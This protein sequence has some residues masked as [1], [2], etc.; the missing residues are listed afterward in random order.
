[1]TTRIFEA[2]D[3]ISTTIKLPFQVRPI[4]E[5]RLKIP[6]TIQE[7]AGLKLK[8]F[9]KLTAIESGIISAFR[10]KLVQ[11]VAEQKRLMG[12][13]FT[14]MSVALQLDELDKLQDLLTDAD[15]LLLLAEKTGVDAEKVSDWVERLIDVTQSFNTDA[16][17]L[18][19]ELNI[20]T[21]IVAMRGEDDQ[22]DYADTYNNLTEPEMRLVLDFCYEEEGVVEEMS[23]EE[24]KKSDN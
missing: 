13:L 23:T 11:E 19:M 6:Y 1:M 21:F 8:S 7:V 17:R 5:D 20:I 4:A 16:T 22:W 12:L 15:R 18:L 10:V 9:S 24:V 3:H 14:E 2:V